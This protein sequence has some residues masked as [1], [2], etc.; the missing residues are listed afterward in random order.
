MPCNFNFSTF[1]FSENHAPVII[2]DKHFLPLGY[3]VTIL[4][5]KQTP[6]NEGTTHTAMYC[7]IMLLSNTSFVKTKTSVTANKRFYLQTLLHQNPLHLH[8]CHPSS[9]NQ[10]PG[11]RDPHQ[12]GR[13]MVMGDTPSLKSTS[14]Q[15]SLQPGNGEEG[16]L[17]QLCHSPFL[18]HHLPP[19]TEVGFYY[20]KENN[21]SSKPYN[22]YSGSHTGG[23]GSVKFKET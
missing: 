19:L 1:F 15:S 7:I 21:I 22:F 5:L 20:S 23:Y 16:L 10:H 9:Q 2:R 3:F 8:P 13:E 14:E 6:A 12:W 18:C 11:S 4:Q 17:P